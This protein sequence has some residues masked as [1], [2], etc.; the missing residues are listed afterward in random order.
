MKKYIFLVTFFQLMQLDAQHFI[1]PVADFDNGRKLIILYQKS[2]QDIELWFFNPATGSAMRGLSSFLAPA[3]VRMMPSGKGFS[4]IDQ[5]YIKIKE[6]DKRSARTLPIYEPIGL[7][8]CMNWIDEEN[9]Y[10]TALQGEFYQIFQGD[11]QANV[12]QMTYEEIDALYPQKIGSKLFYI[13]RGTK[14]HASIVEKLW[15]QDEL[16]KIIIPALDNKP[17]F[18]RMISQQEGFYLQAPTKKIDNPD[19][20]YQFACHHITKLDEKWTSEKLF[21]FYIPARYITGADRLYE[22]IK[23]FLPNCTL[24]P[25]IYFVSW[26]LD[27]KKFE[28]LKFNAQRKIIENI[29]SSKAI[30]TS[31]QIF[32]PYVCK[33]QIL[34]G[35]IVPEQKTLRLLEFDDMKIN[36]PIFYK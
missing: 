36:L 4:F 10:F 33:D 29:G 34:C 12:Q 8:S 3:N 6:F 1:Y 31:E 35:L 25:D 22:S 16:P 11:M 27:C 13:Q 5:G 18:L 2:L 24:T 30:D 19:D 14:N 26:N 20:C 15:N 23:P 9:F 21:N 28:L 17:C 32:A 7:F